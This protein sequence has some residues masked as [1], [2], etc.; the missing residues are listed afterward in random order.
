MEPYTEFIGTLQ[1]SG[2]WLVKVG[3]ICTTMRELQFPGLE[4][5]G[6]QAESVIRG[7]VNST[8]T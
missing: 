4:F 6:L 8:N 7:W 2:F 5:E 3:K 1:N